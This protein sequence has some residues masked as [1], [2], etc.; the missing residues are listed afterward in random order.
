MN[1]VITDKDG[2]NRYLLVKMDPGWELQKWDNGGDVIKTG[3]YKGQVKREGWR[4]MASGNGVYPHN[5][6]HAILIISEDLMLDQK[7][8]LSILD[9]MKQVVKM[10]SEMDMIAECMAESVGI[11]G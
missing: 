2:N 5:I 4:K 1:L 7:G 9:G 6:K 10:L 11:K 8:T 3:K